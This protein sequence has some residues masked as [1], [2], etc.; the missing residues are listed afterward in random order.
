MLGWGLKNEKKRERDRE[1]RWAF[2]SSNHVIC[3]RGAAL[4][5]CVCVSLSFSVYL[6]RRKNSLVVNHFFQWK[7]EEKVL[8]VEK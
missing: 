3:W 6:A 4:G 1:R 7:T 2:K 5:R 8:N